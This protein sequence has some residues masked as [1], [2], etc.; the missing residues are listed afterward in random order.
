MVKNKSNHVDD[1]SILGNNVFQSSSETPSSKEPTA[2]EMALSLARKNEEKITELEN[3]IN[4]PKWAQKILISNN[5]LNN[6][7]KYILLVFF[8]ILIIAIILFMVISVYQLYNL[9]DVLEDIRN[10]DQ[11]IINDKVLNQ[12]NDL[13]FYARKIINLQLIVVGTLAV[14]SI[15]GYILKKFIEKFIDNLT[16]QKK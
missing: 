4:N 1:T 6:V 9:I 14:I 10:S 16:I 12:F 8:I 5:D 11:I 13:F 2:G 7:I 3:D 15:F